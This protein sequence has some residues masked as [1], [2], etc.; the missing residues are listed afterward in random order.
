MD[1]PRILVVD[2]DSIVREVLEQIITGF[3]MTCDLAE[4][5]KQGIEKL[6]SSPYD[7]ILTDITMPVMDG[8]QFLREIKDITPFIP[9]AIITGYPTF[10]NAVEA[11]REGARDFI[12][13]PF[14]VEKIK[15][16]IDR[17]LK[18]KRLIGNPLTGK[19]DLKKELI[20]RLQ[21]IAILQSI[22]S[23]LDELY[24]NRKIYERIV[25]MVSRLLMAR[26][27]AFGIIKNNR[28][29]IEAA[30][31]AVKKEIPISEPI[32]KIINNR[33]SLLLCQGEKNPLNNSILKS[34]L[35]IIPLIINGEVFGVLNITNKIDN[36]PFSEDE[37][38]LAQAFG[39]KVSLRIENNALYELFY[40]NLL[41]TLRS[42]IAS[43]EAR[44]SYTKQ[45]SERVTNYAIEI[46]EVMGLNSEER[47]SIQFGGYLHDIG[48]IGVRD[49][50]LLKPGNLTEEEMA[51]IRLHPVIGESIVRPL[52][53]LP[54][55]RE[56]ILHHHERFDGRGYPAGLAGEDIP[57]LARIL[58][59]ADTYDAMTSTRPYRPAMSHEIAIK[60]LRNNSGTQFDPLVV[61]AF[62]QTKTGKG[63][64]EG[65][66]FNLN[67]KSYQRKH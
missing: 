27:V 12:V 54:A 37:I 32:E 65:N 53:F 44:D 55:E 45:H 29:R 26:D 6:Q 18:E 14:K 48:K 57:L 30:T 60:E 19:E 50:V 17:L 5:G 20:K 66:L 31:M 49:T 28:L 16:T 62:L 1:R 10:E 36:S 51:E 56:L 2:D 21:E 40:S 42:L 35:L 63:I 47:E 43:I 24:D 15:T 25:E 34:E 11:M 23:E 41:N 39:K 58:A 22:S 52:K 64:H 33:T 13:K 38:Y 61:K 9:V 7:L 67:E 46:A 59:V 8:I 4:N 3:G